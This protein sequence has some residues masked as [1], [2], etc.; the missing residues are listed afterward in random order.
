MLRFL[1]DARDTADLRTRAAARTPQAIAV[2]AVA[3][4]TALALM[5]C[6]AAREFTSSPGRDASAVAPA[7]SAGGTSS[8]KATTDSAT[9]NAVAPSEARAVAPVAFH[10]PAVGDEGP[11]LRLG[12]RPSASPRLRVIQPSSSRLSVFA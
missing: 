9:G 8:G 4:I 10:Q 2:V 6:S 1:F 7:Q 11:R 12:A 5:G 3:G